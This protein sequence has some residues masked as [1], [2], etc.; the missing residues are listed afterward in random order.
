MVA[1]Y[2]HFDLAT[3]PKPGEGIMC[4]WKGT[5]VMKLLV[6]LSPNSNHWLGIS[7]WGTRS[8]RDAIGAKV[9]VTAAAADTSRRFA[10]V[11][12]T[13]PTTTCACTLVLVPPTPSVTSRFVG[14]MAKRR[15][16]PALLRTALSLLRRVRASPP[17]HPLS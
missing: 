7:L 9:T 17:L 16:S 15:N 4:I 5:P 3:I 12:A 6:N 14:R 2:V 11:G 8:N 10:A 1:N 13:S